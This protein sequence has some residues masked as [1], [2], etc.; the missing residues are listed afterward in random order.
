M[1]AEH[2]IRSL[3]CENFVVRRYDDTDAERVWAVH[4]QALRASPL[5]FVEDA[6]LDEELRDVPGQYLETSG[7]FLVGVL[8]DVVAIGGFQRRAGGAAAEIEHLRVHPNHQR[9][10]FGGRILDALES[11]AR[12]RG[13][14]RFVLE[15]SEQLTAARSLYES[16]GYEVTERTPHPESGVDLLRYSKEE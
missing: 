4:E 13:V 16:R 12:R 10:G 15:T 7:E 2:A 3:V 14:E 6:P 8:D 9:Q 11:R 1:T 5:P